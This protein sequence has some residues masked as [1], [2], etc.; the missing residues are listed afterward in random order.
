MASKSPRINRGPAAAAGNR[1]AILEAA[2][3]LF[4]ERGFRVPVSAIAKEAGVGQGVMYR[5]FPTRLDLAFAVFEDNLVELENLAVDPGPDTF[6]RL[7]ERLVD[8]TIE[9][10][11][12][13]E[14]LVDARRN[15]P[16]YDGATR[17][18]E[19]LEAALS[20]GR[21]AGTVEQG[22]TADDVMMAVRMCFGV[23]VTSLHEADVRPNVLRALEL[24]PIAF[25][26]PPE[27]Q[28]VLTRPYRGST[29][30]HHHPNS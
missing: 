11:A 16:D 5:H 4:I 30:V 17:M 25:S 15:A 28:P 21:S 19:L 27:Q 13:I 26:T 1:R 29:P 3:K 14:M 2:Q 7:W 22:A 18:Q 12:F 20:A 6:A 24:L 8:M 10:A 23:V 9:Q